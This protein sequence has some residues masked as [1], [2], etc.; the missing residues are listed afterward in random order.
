MKIQ[1]LLAITLLWVSGQVS[2][3][4][5]DYSFNG[6]INNNNITECYEDICGE[7]TGIL[8][9]D[10][11]QTGTS[12]LIDPYDDIY[13]YEIASL[14]I[15]FSDGFEFIGASYMELNAVS[16]PYGA[17]VQDVA[18]WAFDANGLVIV[19][20]S[21]HFTEIAFETND[22]SQILNALTSDTLIDRSH[23]NIGY[24]Y[25][26]C[27]DHSGCNGDIS[28]LTEVPVPAAVW[29][30]GSGLMGLIGLARRKPRV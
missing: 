22:I 6:E 25:P 21:F 7:F 17:P 30:F 5:V 20:F 14:S 2:A 15:T 23:V 19:E 16:D 18:L 11:E 10:N 1:T 4:P 28:S 26:E 9:I 24:Y 13:L 12:L 3:I 27:R 8:T 29:L